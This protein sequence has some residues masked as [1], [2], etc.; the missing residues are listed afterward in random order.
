M[1]TPSRKFALSALT[2]AFV[3][4]SAASSLAFR[5]AAPPASAD[6]DAKAI[7]SLGI[8]NAR[9]YSPTDLEPG[10]DRRWAFPRL[11]ASQLALGESLVFVLPGARAI[12]LPLVAR[13][14]ITN[15]SLALS[16]VDASQGATASVVIHRGIVRAAIELSLATGHESWILETDPNA[17]G[18]E[19]R[20]REAPPSG[21]CGG[22]R[23]V[24]QAEG[25][26]AAGDGG[27]ADACPDTGALVDLL[28]TVTPGFLADAP[29]A[30]A[31]E[32]AILGDVAAANTA[33]VASQCLMRYRIVDADPSSSEADV[34]VV[35]DAP[36]TGSLGADLSAL[37]APNDGRW[38]AVHALRDE[39]RAD[40]VTVYSD[41]PGEGYVGIAIGGAG[42]PRQAFS[43]IGT[44]DGYVLAHELGHNMGCCHAAGDGGGCETGGLFPF[45]LGWRFFVGKEQYR[46]IM[47]YAPGT[48]IGFFSNPN[49]T[50]LGVPTGQKPTP[51]NGFTGADNARTQN[52]T[53]GIVARY[54]CAA[55]NGVDCDGDG[56]DD[57]VAIRDGL[58]PDCNFNGIPDGCDIDL[59]ISLDANADGVPDECPRNDV[60]FSLPPIATLDTFGTGV[61]VATRA[62]SSDLVI[63]VGA[64]GRDL[65]AAANAGA[66]VVTTLSGGA[67]APL[68]YL[69]ANDPKQN[70]F[71]G[72]SVAVY[73]RP[74]NATPAFAERNMALLGAF[75]WPQADTSGQY[76]SIGS[77]YL[78]EQPV[79]GAWRQVQSQG[80]VQPWRWSPPTTGAYAAGLYALL[81]YSVA[82]GH[83]PNENSDFIVAGA[84]GR[85]E[86]RGAVY[87]VKNPSTGTF[88]DKPTFQRWFVRADGEPGDN[89][90]A[91][92]SVE[93]AIQ[94]TG[95]PR[96]GVIM[97]GPGFNSNTGIAMLYER[98]VSASGFGTSWVPASGFDLRTPSTSPY[99]LLHQGDRFGASV[100]IAGRL[101]AVGA[102]G[103]SEGRGRVHFFERNDAISNGGKWFYRG[104]FTPADARP[105][106]GFG[107]SLALARAATG[108]DFIVVV[109][110]SKT[111]V[112]VGPSVRTDAGAAYV[113]RKVFGASG[114]TLVE[115]RTLN[116]PATGDEFGYSVGAT[117]GV[118]IIGAPF[119]DPSGLNSGAAKLIPLP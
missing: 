36:G 28:I 23:F 15:Q 46:T 61:S 76:P 47:A 12:E 105:G 33:L 101:A 116:A 89:F 72:R 117:P 108:S 4:T 107:A 54:R 1:T 17:P 21:G 83:A 68:S 71:N 6:P 94:T 112:A 51:A 5:Q 11:R 96:V 39:T 50:Y 82:L 20:Y 65:P 40:L 24:P 27:V 3:A 44:T 78:F 64:P 7:E 52:L 58:A 43:A 75:R 102:P 14:M 100:A 79:G 63:G 87:V 115:R 10:A 41:S 60:E 85:S 26:E 84:P 77:L 97:G 62:G 95:T 106:D 35:L 13:S 91:S 67:Y 31:L 29:S 34:F 55:W 114:A 38:D 9:A 8:E 22:T 88:R 81:G 18:G 57:D 37:A 69:V 49:V 104:F 73:R 93:T 66:A 56:V 59:G 32:A 80:P 30:D 2:T 119:A 103:T 42:D 25:G 90:G 109:G 19:E 113:L 74:A 92:V 16:F 86:G 111:D 70:A 98:A 99:P 45:S 118:G 48:R 110:A 53:A